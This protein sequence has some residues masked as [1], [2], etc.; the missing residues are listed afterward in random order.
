MGRQSLEPKTFT[1]SRYEEKGIMNVN[2]QEHK[3]FTI[4]YTMGILMTQKF[5]T[6]SSRLVWKFLLK[7]LFT[8]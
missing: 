2:F 7:G 3:C 8:I 4:H 1:I 5:F 6:G